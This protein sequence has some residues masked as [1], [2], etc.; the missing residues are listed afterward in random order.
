MKKLEIGAIISQAWD[1]A[2]KHWPLFVLFSFV[3]SALSGGF[4]SVD[5][6]VIANMSNTRDPE[7]LMNLYSQSISYKPIWGTISALLMLYLSYVVMN[8]YVAAYRSGKPYQSL[9]AAFKID[10]V[11]WATY[12]A[13]IVVV[14][15]LI[16]VGCCLCIIPGLYLCVRLWYVPILTATQGASFGDAFKRSWAMTKG[17]FW[18]LFLLALAQIGIAIVGLCACC[19]GVFFADVITNFML[20][21][22][23]FLLMPEQPQPEF[24]AEGATNTADFVETE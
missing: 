11:Q 6:N 14:G 19:V 1:L 17:H 18:E 15:L 9:A 7:V 12:V 21:I 2:V 22:S 10:L 24:I 13:S 20:V 23:F 8:M 3:T 16:F 5:Q 4:A